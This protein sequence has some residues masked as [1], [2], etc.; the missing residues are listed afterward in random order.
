MPFDRRPTPLKSLPRRPIKEGRR[1][2]LVARVAAK[3]LG[4]RLRLAQRRHNRIVRALFD[5]CDDLCQV[6]AKVVDVEPLVLG[7]VRHLFH[8]SKGIH[9][10]AS[11]VLRRPKAGRIASVRKLLEHEVMVGQHDI[12][13]L[14]E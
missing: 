2:E 3:R 14:L 5:V 4:A 13:Y 9:R 6:L 1:L 12:F 11:H 7:L 8:V 10:L